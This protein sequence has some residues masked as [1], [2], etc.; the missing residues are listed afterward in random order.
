LLFY[1]TRGFIINDVICA[2]KTKREK[3]SPTIFGTKRNPSENTG[4][5]GAVPIA[6]HL[7]GVCSLKVVWK[8]IHLQPSKVRALCFFSDTQ[9]IMA[10]LDKQFFGG[11][12]MGEENKYAL[13]FMV[14]SVYFP[15]PGVT[16]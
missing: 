8:Q 11:F 6:L 9:S 13:W 16:V 10:S 12:E 14:G 15:R 2:S 5:N 4:E 7:C 3:R 1:E